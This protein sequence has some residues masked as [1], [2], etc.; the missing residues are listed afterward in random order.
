M[1]LFIQLS[2]WRSMWDY[3]NIAFKGIQAGCI[4]AIFLFY[5][6]PGNL[7]FCPRQRNF[8]SGTWTLCILDYFHYVSACCFVFYQCL[9]LNNGLVLIKIQKELKQKL[10]QNHWLH[11]WLLILSA[12]ITSVFRLRNLLLDYWKLIE[13]S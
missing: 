9:I 6:K 5:N 4:S 7:I 1:L 13:E 3:M 8:S 12:I 10:L 11:C 2:S